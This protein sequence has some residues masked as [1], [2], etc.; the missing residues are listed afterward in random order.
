MWHMAAEGQS[1]QICFI[2]VLFVAI[3]VSMEINRR[4]TYGA[5]Y[6]LLWSPEFSDKKPDK[7]KQSPSFILQ[8]SNMY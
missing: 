5:T 2:T 4:I 1:D 8:Q 7:L 3:V 6:T